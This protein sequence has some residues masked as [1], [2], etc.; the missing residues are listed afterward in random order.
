MSCRHCFDGHGTASTRM[1][2]TIKRKT[3]R[4]IDHKVTRK[5]LG[6]QRHPSGLHQR[7]ELENFFL[8]KVRRTRDGKKRGCYASVEDCIKAAA[9]LTWRPSTETSC[10]PLDFFLE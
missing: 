3:R 4:P 6:A 8:K 7:L 2:H 1:Q 10:G 9:T 5:K